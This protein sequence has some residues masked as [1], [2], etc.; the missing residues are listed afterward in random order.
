MF[1]ILWIILAYISLFFASLRWVLILFKYRK[2]LR[3]ADVVVTTNSPRAFGTLFFTIDA[4]RRIYSGKSIVYFSLFESSG[5]NPFLGS[6]FNDIT[7]IQISRRILR[8]SIMGR[9]VE[10]PPIDFHDPMTTAITTIWQKYFG[11]ENSIVST[12]YQIWRNMPLPESVVDAFPKVRT[13]KVKKAWYVPFKKYQKTELEPE[14]GDVSITNQL[15]QYGAWSNLQSKV[16][17]PYMMLN[18]ED[19]RII[20]HQINKISEAFELDSNIKKCGF[21][22]RYGG[23]DDKGYRD[24]SNLYEYEPAIKYLVSKGYQVYMQ[25]DRFFTKE[26]L[27]EFKGMV[28][29]AEFL[30]VDQNLFH[31][32]VGTESDIFIGDWPVG[33][34]VAVTN[35]I[36]ALIVNA[37]P[38][39][40]GINNSSVYYRGLLNKKGTRYDYKESL[41]LGSYI[42]CNGNPLL[43]DDLFKGNSELHA[44]V[45][46]AEQQRLSSDEILAAVISFLDEDLKS[47]NHDS[48]SHLKKLLP[49]WTPINMANNCRISP[50]WVRKYIPENAR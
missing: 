5:H 15:F 46:S 36:P 44:E 13:D 38:I 16:K 28:V 23:D 39:G 29:D 17:A 4:T 3:K 22:M 34:Q 41:R 18:T 19:K 12:P 10:L 6:A 14:Y 1:K 48:Y 7:L 49:E 24:G 26:E 45:E 43:L 37:W 33:P 25:G 21:H 47:M 30:S 27:E 40:W 35:G 8:F 50:A 9:Q 20:E 42:D 31:I 11:K 32:Y 2:L